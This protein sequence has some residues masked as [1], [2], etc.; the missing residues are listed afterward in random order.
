[1]VSLADYWPDGGRGAVRESAGR[2]SWGRT[3]TTRIAAPEPPNRSRRGAARCGKPILSTIDSLQ[4]R[5]P[6]E[7]LGARL[8]LELRLR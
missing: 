2:S 5:T 8:E 4:Q 6:C 1:M 3:I 7:D